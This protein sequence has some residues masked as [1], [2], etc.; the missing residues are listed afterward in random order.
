MRQVNARG[1]QIHLAYG[2]KEMR[3]DPQRLEQVLRNLM[4]NAVRYVPEGRNIEIRWTE[5][6]PDK[7][8]LH[9]KDDGPGIAPEHQ[10]RLFERF[11][12][13]DESRSRDAGGTGIGLSLVKH[14]M[15]RHGGQ[16]YVRS[17]IGRG[18][19]FV[20]EF[21]KSQPASLAQPG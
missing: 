4:E 8:T 11:Y 17:D 6:G 21:P 5:S 3:A 19:E 14:I 16:V 10:A 7:V 20:C 2:F 18:A 15:H 13:V 9:V 1:H 12:R